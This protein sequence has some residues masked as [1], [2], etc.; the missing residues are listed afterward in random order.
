MN[1]YSH[2]YLHALVYCTAKI[3]SENESPSVMSDSSQPHGL[4]SPWNSPSQKLTVSSLSLLSGD[5]PNPGIKSRSLTLQVDSLPAQPQG[6]SKNT[7]VGS[8]S[9][10]QWIFPTQE[11]NPAL[12]HCRQILYQLSYRGL[13]R[14]EGGLRGRRHMYTYGQF[15]LRYGRNHR[16]IIIIL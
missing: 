2:V 16:N 7:G 11:W 1:L 8:L 4:Y 12:L 10:L 13:R 15:M 6:K 5:L 3:E 14:G 9:L